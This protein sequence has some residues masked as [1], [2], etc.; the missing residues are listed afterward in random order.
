MHE[1]N[2]DVDKIK[3]AVDIVE[4]FKLKLDEL[5]VNQNGLTIDKDILED[6][7]KEF[8]VFTTQKYALMKL[9]KDYNER[10][11]ATISE[12]KM[13]NLEKYLSSK[14]AF[15]SNQSDNIC[16]YCEKFIPKSLLKHY[17]YCSAKREFDVANGIQPDPAELVDEEIELQIPVNEI[18]NSSVKK[19][20]KKKKKET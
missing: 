3:T 1:V 18:P 5:N 10:M 4:A 11:N 13:P 14:F 16:K 20:N 17:R 15:S 6:I 8:V 19:T 7:N 9:V 12:I 2:F